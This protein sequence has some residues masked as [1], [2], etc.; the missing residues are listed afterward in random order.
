MSVSSGVS[1]FQL[2][3]NKTVVPVCIDEKDDFGVLRASIDL[4]NDIYRVSGVLPELI[5]NTAAH[6]NRMIIVGSVQKNSLPKQIM[7]SE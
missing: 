6:K 2:L 5:I 4:Q 1:S 7:K 3:Q